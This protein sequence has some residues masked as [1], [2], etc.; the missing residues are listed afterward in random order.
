MRREHIR[1]MLYFMAW[2]LAL[3]AMGFT[4]GWVCKPAQAVEI[5]VEHVV[6]E[7]WAGPVKM[8]GP[9]ETE[10]ESE[11][12][13]LGEFTTYGYC[14]CAKC[15]GKWA[16][17]GLTAT[18]TNPEAMRTVAVD[19]DVIPLGSLLLIGGVSYIAE[20]T[21]AGINGQAIDIFYP[22][23]EMALEHGVQRA[24]VWLYAD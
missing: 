17:Y 16:E 24:E 8:G 9:V 1:D 5:V 13:S 10:P 2:V 11:V 3:L 15:C 12:T 21:G 4:L 7:T 14:A 6:P 20:D 18:G 23:H 22:T 19:P